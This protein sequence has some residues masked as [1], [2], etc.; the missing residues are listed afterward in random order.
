MRFFNF[1]QLIIIMFNYF[2]VVT[3][4]NITN[5][6]CTPLVVFLG[7]VFHLSKNNE[8]QLYNRILS[9]DLPKGQSA[10]IW[11]ARGAGKSTF[12]KQQYPD[13]IY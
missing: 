8:P 2:R 5:M 9:L 13:A 12:L 11:S 4:E 6:R 3:L 1:L 10:F 7:R